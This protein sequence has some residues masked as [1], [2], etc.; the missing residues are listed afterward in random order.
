MRK[1]LVLLGGCIECSCAPELAMGVVWFERAESFS[2]MPW[3]SFYRQKGLP[4]WHTGGG[5]GLQWCELIACITGQD[6]FN[7][8]LRCPSLY[9]G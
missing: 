5:K 1:T 6:A 7:A 8:W 4:Q 2:C 3:A 9:Q